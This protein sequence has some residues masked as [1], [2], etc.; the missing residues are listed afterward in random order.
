MKKLRT[1]VW[2]I[3]DEYL[4]FLGRGLW[5]ILALFHLAF[6]VLVAIFLQ[7]VVKK[8]DSNT[9]TSFIEKKLPLWRLFFIG[10]RRTPLSSFFL[11]IVCPLLCIG[12]VPYVAKEFKF[13]CPDT[14]ICLGIG[15]ISYSIALWWS[16]EM[17]R[18]AAED[19][20]LYRSRRL[21]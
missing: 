17:C 15:L 2:Y 5:V 16:L 14:W 18:D 12:F 21:D 19:G 1:V 8:L 4:R 10:W 11:Y 7:E 6:I 9:T 3:Y 13:V 20:S